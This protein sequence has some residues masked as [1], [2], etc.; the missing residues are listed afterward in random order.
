ME[1]IHVG[2]TNI[3]LRELLKHIKPRER[4]FIT[5]RGRTVA[6]L[7]PVAHS[8]KNGVSCIFS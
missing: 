7:L 3:D 4:I 8:K 2:D 6:Q 5:S 1:T